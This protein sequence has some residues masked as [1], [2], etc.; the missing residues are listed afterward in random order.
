MKKILILM[1]IVAASMAYADDILSSILKESKPKSSLVNYESATKNITGNSSLPQVSN[2]NAIDK[3]SND[4]NQLNRKLQLEKVTAEIR[5][6]KNTGS[7]NGD[8]GSS[9]SGKSQTIV[10]GVAINITGKKIA[11]LQFA[12]GGSYMV[13]IGSKVGKYMVTDISMNGVILSE[14]FGAKKH[15]S[16][17]VIFLK[18]VYASNSKRHTNLAGKNSTFFTPSPVITSANSSSDYV[19][20]IVALTTD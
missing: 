14:S 10:T 7:G 12:D 19:P 11:W 17:K 16:T 2:L 4:I 5:K 15:R 1:S 9:S 8:S 20:P 13:N 3:D 18:R 6:L